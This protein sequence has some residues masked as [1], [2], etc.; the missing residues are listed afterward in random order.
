MQCDLQAVVVH[1]EALNNERLQ[2][3]LVKLVHII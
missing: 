1:V 3:Q 2:S